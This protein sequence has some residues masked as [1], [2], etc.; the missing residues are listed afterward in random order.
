MTTDD[1]VAQWLDKLRAMDEH[2]DAIEGDTEALEGA[3]D[4]ISQAAR[5][6]LA[7][8]Q[9]ADL[10]IRERE[11]AHV[12]V[13]ALFARR[14]YSLRKK[15]EGLAPA[16][17]IAGTLQA[18]DEDLA[19]YRSELLMVRI[20]ESTFKPRN[21]S[22]GIAFASLCSIADV[23]ASSLGE[24]APR[25]PLADV[26]PEYH[27]TA[28]AYAAELERRYGTGVLEALSEDEVAYLAAHPELIHR[29]LRNILTCNLITPMAVPHD[30][31]T[32]SYARMLIEKHRNGEI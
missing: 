3:V 17:H 6:W 32:A 8:I 29:H 24:D 25:D 16:E 7:F 15:A 9:N 11:S 23:D 1:I 5:E 13:R 4:K 18:V 28:K 31:A 10:T 19:S 21:A 20:T 12:R 14:L 26:Q 2:S 27:D 22:V 30:I